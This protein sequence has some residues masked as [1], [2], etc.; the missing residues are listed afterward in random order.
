MTAASALGASKRRGNPLTTASGVPIPSGWALQRFDTFGTG[1]SVPGPVRLRTLYDE[2]QF[3]AEVDGRQT[4]PNSGV[5][6][7]QQQQYQHFEDAT[8]LW[9]TDHVTIQGR[10]QPDNSIKSGQIAYRKAY[11][12]FIFEA[13][14][15]VPSTLGTWVE[16]WAFAGSGGGDTSEIDVEC[17]QST[18]GTSWDS[19][20]VSVGNIPYGTPISDDSHFSFNSSTGILRYDNAAFNKNTGPHYYT[21]YYNDAGAGEIR[22]YIDGALLYHVPS[23]KWNNT[24][25]GTGFGPDA[26]MLL[27]LACGTLNGGNF[28][29]T[30]AS[31][32]TWSGDLDIYSVGVYAP[33]SAGRAIPI[34]QAWNAD[35]INA[36]VTI[37]NNDLTITSGANATDQPCLALDSVMTGTG[38]YYWE[39]IS[40]G[41]TDTPGCGV[42]ASGST[43]ADFDYIGRFPQTLGWYSSGAVVNNNAVVD[44]WATFGPG[45]VRLCFALDMVNLKIWGRVG[46]A[47]NWNNAA[48]G[49]QNPATNTGGFA[50]PSAVQVRV[51]PAVNLKNTAETATGAFASGSWVGPPPAGF[52]QIGP[53]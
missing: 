45:S 30:I 43:N 10:G 40:S 23:W 13:R 15:T 33:G 11:R 4:I 17:L 53:T 31:P 47:G 34:G 46:A 51:A 20:S 19:H 39:V 8:W 32:S 12:S 36:H 44:T 52:G 3:F 29:G 24:L 38:K 7:N 22:R 1:G 2:A 27:D 35:F 26:V 9:G 41:T 28:P 48:I 25:G 6:N 42:G 50:L 18:D 16:F 5:I 49:S 21:I 14:F 37:S